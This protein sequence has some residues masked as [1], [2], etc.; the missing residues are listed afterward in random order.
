MLNLRFGLSL[1]TSVGNV[2]ENSTGM[3][4]GLF[5][6]PTFGVS[7]RRWQW[8]TSRLALD[9]DPTNG[10]R[11]SPLKQVQVWFQPALIL[12][13]PLFFQSFLKGFPLARLKSVH[14][15]GKFGIWSRYQ[16][17]LEDVRQPQS[18]LKFVTGCLLCPL[19]VQ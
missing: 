10:K 5:Q 16:L 7:M 3:N 15:H 9:Y 2:Q 18:D 8:Y 4:S 1:Y 6:I 17:L 12:Q 11:P 14:H 13:P 19:W